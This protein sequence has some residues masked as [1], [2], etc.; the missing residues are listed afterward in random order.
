[1]HK[2][3]SIRSLLLLMIFLPVCLVQAQPSQDAPN[4]Y[5]SQAASDHD[6]KMDWWRKARLGMF[7]HWGV[8]AVPAGAYKGQE[9]G[10]L[11]EWIMH[12]ASIPRKEYEQFARQFNPVKY[13]P[14][15]WVRMAKDAGMKYIVI[16]SKHHDG[17]ALFDSKAS[18]WNVVKATPYGKDLLKPLVEACRKQGMK[19]GFYYSQANDWYNP[20]GAAA[21]GHW[22]KTQE[23]SMDEYID[24][25]AIPQV[26]EILTLYGDVVEL[27]WDVP[28][29][30]NRE[31]AD[32]LAA[33]MSLQPGIITNDRLGGHHDGD[34]TTPEQYIPATGIP[35]RDW[36]TC[37]T[38]NDTWGFKTYDDNWKSSTTLIRNLIDIASKG[39]NYL[40]NVGPT[41]EGEFPAPIVERLQAIG[42]W[43]KAN[44]E[45][46]YGTTASPFT[47]LPWGR[48]TKKVEG[49]TTTLYLHV[50]AW[51]KDGK[52][53]VPGLTSKIQTAK[54]LANRK[55]LKTATTTEG[56]VID[57][58]A[59]APDPVASVIV[60]T[61]QEPLTIQPYVIQQKQDGTLIL[62]AELA[63]IKSYRNE[64]LAMTEGDWDARNIGYWTN[65]RCWVSWKVNIHK[66]GTYTIKAIAATPAASSKFRI[67][68]GDQAL[69][70][71]LN[72]TG[73]YN[74]YQEVT[75]GKITID[76][77]GQH[78][79][80]IY[81]GEGWN[82]I[83]L[84][85]IK[86][87]P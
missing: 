84:R 78:T 81:P 13:N 5:S 75:L 65:P 33:L 76:K 56:L 50:F 31:R 35:G 86:L 22:D 43:T 18:D 10:G 68:T 71:T 60:L 63:N 7:I 52:L 32:K 25:V 26:R 42:K 72:S 37:M 85:Q 28:T 67:E 58:P 54:L 30:M 29:D 74:E 57:V 11:G 40:L 14:E 48:A 34:I 87:L 27:W 23:G 46:I 6:K 83:N 61:T 62:D 45:A 9:I 8:Y 4:A 47:I 53:L 24:K 55:S 80:A 39:G 79:I 38:M 64:G 16:T 21:R 1:M 66:P 69:E 20:G 51:P 77:A 36:E 59:K 70:A 12:D 19:L 17:F 15:A 2:Q 49:N 82:P 41:A 73:D 3:I 44:G